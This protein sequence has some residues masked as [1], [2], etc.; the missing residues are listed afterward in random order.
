MNQCRC[1]ILL[2]GWALKVQCLYQIGSSNVSNENMCFVSSD[3][4]GNDRSFGTGEQPF[5]MS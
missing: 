4:S 2:E 1:C 3:L 5:V